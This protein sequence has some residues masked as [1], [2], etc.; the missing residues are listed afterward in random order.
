MRE[1]GVKQIHIPLSVE[2]FAEIEK[3]KGKMTW[4]AFALPRLR[5]KDVPEELK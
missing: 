5:L 3:L 1:L 2:E 4:R